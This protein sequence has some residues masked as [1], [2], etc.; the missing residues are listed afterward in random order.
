MCPAVCCSVCYFVCHRIQRITRHRFGALLVSRHGG[1]PVARYRGLR[2]DT[3]LCGR[4]LETAAPAFCSAA[5]RSFATGEETSATCRYMALLAFLLAD[6]DWAVCRMKSRVSCLARSYLSLHAGRRAAFSGMI[7][8][9]NR[10]NGWL[11]LVCFG[12]ANKVT[13]W[14]RRKIVCGSL[15]CQCGPHTA[16]F[17]CFRID[18]RCNALF[19]IA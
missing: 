8:R 4:S 9:P 7:A 12:Y 6:G 16:E 17:F 13:A 5:C 14:I 11:G 19:R 2:R 1:A 3:A 18:K 10:W 15:F